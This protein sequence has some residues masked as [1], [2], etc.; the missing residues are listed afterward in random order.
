[1][2][3]LKEYIYRFIEKKFLDGCSNYNSLQVRKRSRSKF[4]AREMFEKNNI[5]YAKGVIFFSPLKAL[6]FIKDN[7]FPVVVKPNVGGYSRGSY[8]PITNYKEFIKAFFLAKIWWP[9]S[10]IESYLEGKNYRVVAFDGKII[11]VARRY[12]AFIIGDGER[13]ISKLIDEVNAIRKSMKLFPVVYSI[14]KDTRIKSYLKKRDLKLDSIP[15][16]DEMIR[17]YHRISLIGGG[18][19]ET[20]ELDTIPEKNKELFIKVLKIFDAKIF[21]IDVILEKGVEYPY[22]EQKCIFLEVNSRPYLK[23]HDYPRHGKV[24]HLKEFYKKA[25]AINPEDS[26]IY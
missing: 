24:P 22:D 26:D 20:I 8:F 4:L 13:S 10:V 7:G 25:D 12:P 18:T 11:T 17:L 6:K 1:M 19:L 3:K 9:I 16:K 14:A 2:R 23:M 15:K 5:P 21:G